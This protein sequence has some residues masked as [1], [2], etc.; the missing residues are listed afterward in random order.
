MR[1][2]NKLWIQTL[3]LEK[4]ILPALYS[5]PEVPFNTCEG[6]PRTPL[7]KSLSGALENLRPRAHL[8]ALLGPD[9]CLATVQDHGELPGLY[10]AKMKGPR[11]PL[12]HPSMKAEN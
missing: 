11:G 5:N 9:P 10:R 4:K 12:S 1:S 2:K 8:G 7:H 6:E 3:T